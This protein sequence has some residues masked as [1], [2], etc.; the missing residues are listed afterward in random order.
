MDAFIQKSLLF[1]ITLC[2][3]SVSNWFASA[4]ATIEGT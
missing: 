1:I 4:V 3:Q 2:H